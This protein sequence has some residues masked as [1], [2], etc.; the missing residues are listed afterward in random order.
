MYMAGWLWED[1]SELW[2]GSERGNLDYRLGHVWTAQTTAT[3]EEK[4]GVEV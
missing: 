4:Y 3:Q 2:L 1:W